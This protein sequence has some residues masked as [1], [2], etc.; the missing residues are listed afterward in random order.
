[1][2]ATRVVGKPK[3]DFKRLRPWQNKHNRPSQATLC[4]SPSQPTSPPVHL[5]AVM[6]NFSNLPEIRVIKSKKK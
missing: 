3:Q 4:G 6:A 5:T 1:V 2:G